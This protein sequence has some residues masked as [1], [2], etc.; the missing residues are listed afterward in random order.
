MLAVLYFNFELDA[1][2]PHV[3]GINFFKNLIKSNE[4]FDLCW[5]SCVNITELL[6]KFLQ[7]LVMYIC[8]NT[9]YSIINI[10]RAIHAGQNSMH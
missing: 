6:L 2:M 8:K 1:L 4:L 7:D 9:N 5:I 10:N 3:A